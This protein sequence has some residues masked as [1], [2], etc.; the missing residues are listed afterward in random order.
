MYVDMLG[1]HLTLRRQRG[2]S[3]F[4]GM[5]LKSMQDPLVTH[6]QVICPSDSPLRPEGIAHTPPI[7]AAPIALATA[8]AMATAV[9]AATPLILTITT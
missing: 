1:L 3:T 4:R 6:F 5:G 8:A 2:V 9:A 7:P